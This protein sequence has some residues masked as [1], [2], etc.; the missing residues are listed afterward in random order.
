MVT[1]ISYA[2][3]DLTRSY[4]K[5]FSII[6]TLFISLFILS[7]IINLETGLKKELNNN[8]KVLLGGDF[9]VDTRSKKINEQFLQE[10]KQQST[11]SSTIEFSTMLTGSLN[12]DTNAFFIRLKAVDD[13]YPLY[14]KVFSKPE[15]AMQRLQNEE[16]AIVVNRKIFETLNLKVDD[17]VYVKQ[18]PFKVVGFVETVPDLGRALLFGDFAVVS[19]KAF[20]TLNITSLGSFVNY[21]YKIKTNNS[22]V[23]NFVNEKLKQFPTYKI[24]LPENAANN[25]KRLISNFSEFLSLVSISAMLIAGIGIS[26]TLISFINQKNTSIA[27][28]KS[29]GFK[30]VEIKRIFYLEVFFLLFIITTLA[31]LLSLAVI[32]QANLF[33]SNLGISLESEFSITNY[34]LI[35]LTGLLVVVIF[36]IPT[37]SSIEQIK[38][39]SLFRNV[40]QLTK[41]QFGLKNSVIILFLLFTLLGIFLLRSDKLYYTTTYFVFFFIFC[42]VFYLLSQFI[43]YILKKIKFSNHLPLRFAMKNITQERSI[44]PI[45]V[46]SLGIG[47]TLLLT[48]T[49]VGTNFKRELEKSIPEIAPDFFYVS[50]QKDVKDNFIS[51]LKK[52]DPQLKYETVPIAPASVAKIN[53]VDP[54]TYIKSSNDSFWVLER[55]RR[56]SWL[57]TPPQDNPIVE[58]KWFDLQSDQL[59][60]SLDAKVARNF[61]VNLNDELTLKIYGREVTGTVTSLRQVDY[62][63][64]S[65]NFAMII[66]P[67]FANQLPHEY[68][69]TAKFSDPKLIQEAKLVQE[70]P[71]ISAI[72]VSTYLGKITSLVNKIFIAVV[73]ISSVVV[74]VGLMVIASAVVVQARIG[75]Y[76]NLI[77]KI[78]GLR[79]GKLIQAN[80]IEFFITYVSIFLIAGLFGIFTSRFVIETI[81]RLGWQFELMPVF[82]VLFIIGALTLFLI[83]VNTYRFLKPSV[84]PMVRNE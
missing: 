68:I 15:N 84:Y 29:V 43:I 54:L 71:N 26:N 58:G 24:R 74:I 50:I 13:Q 56:I 6:V 60:I 62:R 46:L 42:G 1:S 4:K 65:I 67:K 35:L 73:I 49:L 27:I 69:A 59:Q 63:D 36:C 8:A 7:L 11:V 23:L 33:I 19:N 37:I 12:D 3:R 61:G 5:L 78:L 16:N 55:D 28:M 57:N 48:L 39:T 21:E 76:Q 81:F 72:K 9:E 30:S 66:N 17:T 41:F 83:L 64:L 18:S 22:N 2:L 40:F 53:G 79:S 77:F 34:S 32:P 45:T 47:A 20:D 51:S 14:G 70:F 52:Q 25:L 80:L 82:N 44:F 31:Y 10:L 75:V 38:A